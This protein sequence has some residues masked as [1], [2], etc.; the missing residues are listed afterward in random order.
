MIFSDW[1]KFQ[2]VKFFSSVLILWTESVLNE[3][4]ALKLTLNST[5]NLGKEY[6]TKVVDNFN[7]FSESINTPLSDKV[8]GV[9]VSD[10]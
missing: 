7:I 4:L 5:S 2:S 9:M 10:S 1:A 6:D 8:S 3:R